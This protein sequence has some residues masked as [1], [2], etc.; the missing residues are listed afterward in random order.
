[1]DSMDKKWIPCSE[2]FPEDDNYILLSFSNFSLPLVG[3]YEEDEEGGAFYVGDEEESCVSQGIIVNAWQ[4]LPK[5]YQEDQDYRKTMGDRIREM[6]DEEL[7][8]G[9]M[10]LDGVEVSKKIPFCKEKGPCYEIIDAGELIPE[11]MCRQCLMEWLQSKE[12]IPVLTESEKSEPKLIICDSGREYH[13]SYG[14]LVA[15]V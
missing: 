5:P 9:I 12:D 4:P 1:M 8:D 2:R 13:F 3:R 15:V 11:E 10:E 6:T 14:N 7:V